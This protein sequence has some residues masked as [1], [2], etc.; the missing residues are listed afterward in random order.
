M[1]F[2][3]FDDIVL[4]RDIPEEML[5]VGD[6]ATIVEYHP[7]GHD[8]DG[9]TLEVFNALGDTVAVVTVPASAIRP[10]SEEDIPAVRS[11]GDSVHADTFLAERGLGYKTGGEN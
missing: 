9:Y 10:V 7:V 2:K 1:K 6:I 11:I 8:E 4:S 5:K 3:L